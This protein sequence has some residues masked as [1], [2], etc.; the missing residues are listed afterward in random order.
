MTPDEPPI[1]DD[2]ALAS[3]ARRALGR[4]SDDGL[5]VADPN[6]SGFIVLPDDWHQKAFIL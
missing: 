3:A 5:P 1:P 2:D 6:V 4:L